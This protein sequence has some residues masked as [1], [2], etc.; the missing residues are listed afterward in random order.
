VQKSFDSLK[1]RPAPPLS[2]QLDL[3]SDQW[4]RIDAV[5]DRMTADYKKRAEMLIRRLDVTIDS[6]FWSERVQQLEPKISEVY[7]PH[8]EALAE[9][10]PLGVPDL[11]ASS[12]GKHLKLV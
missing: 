3:N 11:L 9:W 7:G 6:F 4:S 12:E 8:R 2:Q 1:K 5:A 10:H